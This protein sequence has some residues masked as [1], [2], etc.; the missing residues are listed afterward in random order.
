MC[1]IKKF[2]RKEMSICKQIIGKK[3]NDI[4]KQLDFFVFNFGEEIE[5]CIHSYCFTKITMHGDILLSYLDEYLYPD[6]TP[7]EEEEY[8]K[9][10]LHQNSLL[11]LSI[12]RVKKE[13]SEA[14][15]CEVRI[16]ETADLDI[17]FNNGI[18]LMNHTVS[19]CEGDEFYR[20]F[21]YKD[22]SQS[23]CVVKY[24]KKQII[25]ETV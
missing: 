5:Y 14:Y 25:I 11:K 1:L 16:S 3:L 6:H 12:E 2:N 10:E 20:I 21:K 7:M 23:H 8:K 22:Y 18:V 15:V 9:D 17:V 19:L 13:L 4:F 24:S